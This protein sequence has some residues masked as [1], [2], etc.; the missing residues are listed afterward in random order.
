M[1]SVEPFPD[2]CGRVHLLQEEQEGEE[3][4]QAADGVCLMT[5]IIHGLSK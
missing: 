1:R 2:P 5:N 3:G 4:Q